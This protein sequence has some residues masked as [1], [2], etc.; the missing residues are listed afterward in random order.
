[1][2]RAKAVMEYE[3]VQEDVETADT[4]TLDLEDE[5]EKGENEDWEKEAHAEYG[6]FVDERGNE[7]EDEAEPED[8]DDAGDEE[9]KGI[10]SEPDLIKMYLKD[11]RATPLLSFA[12]EQ[13]LGKRVARGDAEA[14]Q[15]MIEA[16]LR[17]VVS[18]A[19]RYVNRGMSFGDLLEEGNLG[20]I[21][22]VEKFQYQ[23]GFRFSTYASWWIR[24]AITRA[25]ANQL[26]LVRLPVHVSEDVAGYARTIRQLTQTLHR[27][28]TVEEIAKKMHRSIQRVRVLSQV[29]RSV[30]S[31]DM[32]ISADNDDTLQEMLSDDTA[33]TPET[34]LEDENMKQSIREWIAKLPD[35]ERKVIELRYGFNRD[36]RFTL[37]H[38]GKQ[39][40]LT[41]ERVRQ[42]ESQAIQRLRHLTKVMN[43]EMSDVL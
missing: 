27:T 15:K 30:D 22:A 20:L 7:D 18:I 6:H 32:K 26:R 43:I 10:S 31:L 25:M 12:D 35:T 1:M 29:S 19:K 23:R 36:E 28:P 5:L 2:M 8:S 40:G 39:F 34:P 14:R 9:P 21:R 42:I 4:I 17:L 11:I 3:P 38:I 37:N 41:R 24:Q 33:P 13:E 16:N